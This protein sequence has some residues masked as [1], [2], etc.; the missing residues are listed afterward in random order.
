[1]RIPPSKFRAI[2]CDDVL[3][4]TKATNNGTLEEFY[5]GILCNFSHYLSFH[6]HC[7]VVNHNEDEAN[8]SC[9]RWERMNDV[10]S[11]LCKQYWAQYH[12]HARR[13]L[14]GIV[15]WS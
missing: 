12:S 6:P 13:R 11:P 15:L 1:M 14:F 8:Q 4:Y 2:V 3:R 5:N 7:K 9:G 10:D